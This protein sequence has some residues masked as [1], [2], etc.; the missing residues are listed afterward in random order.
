MK[1]IKTKKAKIKCR[2]AR[3][4][5]EKGRGLMLK[6]KIEPL[7]YI[8]PKEKRYAF[9]TMFM[10]RTIDMVFINRDKK[11]TEKITARPFRF[12]IMPK[13]PVKYVVELPRGYKSKFKIDEKIKIES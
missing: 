2:V 7:L 10:L 1:I 13:K 11:V 3:T 12:L 5:W 4:N 8:F 9:H 6:K